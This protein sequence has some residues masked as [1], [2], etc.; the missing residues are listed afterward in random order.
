VKNKDATYK[1]PPI[2]NPVAGPSL[3]DQFIANQKK[4]PKKIVKVAK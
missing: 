3:L 2:P 4:L 1:G